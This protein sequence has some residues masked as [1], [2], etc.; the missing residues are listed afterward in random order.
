MAQYISD[1][2]MEEY[3]SCD[4]CNKKFKT[5]E[6]T[7]DDYN[8]AWDNLVTKDCC[9]DCWTKCLTKEGLEL[10]RVGNVI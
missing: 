2:I 1:I 3:V 9:S 4:H 5:D 10:Y 7:L 6:I 8:F